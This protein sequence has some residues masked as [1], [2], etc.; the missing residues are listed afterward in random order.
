MCKIFYL[1][2]VYFFLANKCSKH[3]WFFILNFISFKYFFFSIFKHQLFLYFWKHSH[4]IFKK[5][6]KYSF[7]E[8]TMFLILRKHCSWMAFQPVFREDNIGVF[9]IFIL[10]IGILC[11]R[12]ILEPMCVLFCYINM[13][14]ARL[15]L[16]SAD[17]LNADAFWNLKHFSTMG[18][19][20]Y[21][22]GHSGYTPL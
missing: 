3:P 7:G 5:P 21:D 19:F 12:T 14:H 10:H 22:L 11:Y 6:I 20:G 8:P 17:T 2:Q 16:H 4:P 9:I 18:F 15:Q 1:F 13:K